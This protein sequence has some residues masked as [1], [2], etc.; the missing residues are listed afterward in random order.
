MTNTRI[1]LKLS[2]LPLW[3]RPDAEG[4]RRSQK[5]LFL[6]ISIV[7]VSFLSWLPLNIVNIVIDWAGLSM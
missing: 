3:R 2:Q 7:L 6:L 5:T 1:Y 4:D